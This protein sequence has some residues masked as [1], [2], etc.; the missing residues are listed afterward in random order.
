L[1]H[2]DTEADEARITTRF[3]TPLFLCVLCVS[4]VF[5]SA[6][7]A[8]LAAKHMEIVK[9]AG[10]YETVFRDS[11]VIA[12]K[13]TRITANEARLSESRGVAVI[14]GSVF[15]QSPDALIWA[16]SARYLLDSR[17]T[18]LYGDVRVKQESLYI[19]A[20]LLSYAVDQKLVR[21]NSGVTVQNEQQDFRLVGDR[22]TYDL[23]AEV[24]V[25]DSN[26]RMVRTSGSDSVTGTAREMRWLA[27]ESKAL[28]SGEVKV[29]SGKSGLDCDT[30]VFVSSKDSGLAWGNPVLHD[31]SSTGR[32]D[33]VSFRVQAGRLK[34]VA[35][36]GNATSQYQT[37]GNEQID[38]AGNSMVITLENGE[39]SV[40]EVHEMTKGVLVRSRSGE[41]S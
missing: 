36:Q 32:G 13:D 4:V 29:V 22:G 39:V 18:D 24:G 5:L 27:N 7:A 19:L 16:D 2:R 26:P 40:I 1:N 38:V 8:D 10:G 11:V 41:G 23:G 12:D 34:T 3:L 20:P 37:E 33:V 25:V 21:A 35:I 9:T 17:Q 30:L 15:I 14:A 6:E 28:V 31:S